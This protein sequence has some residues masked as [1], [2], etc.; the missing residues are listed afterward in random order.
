MTDD[1]EKDFIPEQEW[2]ASLPCFTASSG[3]LIT[4]PGDSILVVKPWYRDRWN[5]PGGVT[6]AGESP[7]RC[8]ER[9]V[10][11]ETGLT[12]TAGA[13]L[14]IGW[15]PPG[16]ARRARFALTFDCGSVPGP[17][18]IRLDAKEID[19]FAFL[20]LGTAL[21]LLSPAGAR[22][23]QAAWRARRTGCPAYLED[24]R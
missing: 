1:R 8:A 9:E 23:L 10:R 17:E 16:A 3:G 12:V 4:G 22:R 13:L 21:P 19:D 7:R 20:P 24:G 2:L 15:V 5:L 11:E 18:G 6:E 14:A